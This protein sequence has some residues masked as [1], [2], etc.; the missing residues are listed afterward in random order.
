MK[1]FSSPVLCTVFRSQLERSKHQTKLA[2]SKCAHV[3]NFLL[4]PPGRLK[5]ALHEEDESATKRASQS[6]KTMTTTSTPTSTSTS[7]STR[8]LTHWLICSTPLMALRNALVETD[9]AT[10]TM[11]LVMC[12]RLRPR[13]YMPW[14]IDLR[15]HHHHDYPTACRKHSNWSKGT[16]DRGSEL[17]LRKQWEERAWGGGR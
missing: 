7:T 5:Q 3:L 6:I 12:H 2:L 14:T 17:A 10:M 13:V 4:S 1:T 8:S 11:N 16:R 9:G 15:R